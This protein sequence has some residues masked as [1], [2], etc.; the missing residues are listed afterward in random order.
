[1]KRLDKYILGAVLLIW[2]A[3]CLYFWQDTYAG[4]FLW[5]FFTFVKDMLNIEEDTKE[6]IHLESMK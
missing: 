2:G 3:T 6:E 5:V 4:M 1:M